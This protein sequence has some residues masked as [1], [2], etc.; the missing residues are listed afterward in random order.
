MLKYFLIPIL[1]VLSFLSG[2]V[3]NPVTGEKELRLVSESAEINLGAEQYGPTRQMQGGDYT[4][5][6]ELTEY[7]AGVGN[8]LASVADRGLPYE[9]NVIN[10]STPN[11]WALPGGKI[12]VNRGLLTEL[13][14]EAE[15]AAVLGHEI[16]HAAARHGAK[17]MERGMLLQ[18]AVM[19]TGLALRENEYAGVVVGGASLGA[20]LV[21]Q[22]YGRDAELESDYYGMSYMRRAGYDPL[23]AVKLQ[24]TFLRLSEGKQNNWLAG[25]FSSHPP[26]RE[27]VEANRRTAAEMPAGGEVG[28]ERYRQKIAALLKAE[29]A[30]VAYEKGRK[31]L[32]EGK[33]EEAAAL[34]EKAI[35]IEPREALFHALLGD[36]RFKKEQYRL[37]IQ[38]YDRALE[39]NN[40]YFAFFLRRGLAQEKLGN[41]RQ[42]Y[43]DLEKSVQLLPTSPALNVLGNL[44]LEQG[45]RQKAKEFFA[46]A[47]GSE[48]EPGKAAARSFVLLDLPDNPGKYLEVRL[49]LDREGY[50]LAEVSNPTMVTVSEIHFTVRFA[51]SRGRERQ[52]LL[53]IPRS[54]ESG[55]A[56]RVETGIGPVENPEALRGIRA[57]VTRARIAR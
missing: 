29:D 18:G 49:G 30:Y 27:R 42:A 53:R 43:V 38:D 39:R 1:L 48:S 5:D 55:Q 32:S 36:A 6:P 37:A 15:L 20:M 47:A 4:A 12:A 19:A 56:A 35:V 16:V 44:A 3:V 17:G 8:R 54:L 33:T 11:A 14:S 25:L 21:N 10:D 51:D 45:D 41:D 28:A 7:V 23:A 34:A 50:L 57:E 13:E 31:A 24:E 26:S 46:A 52:V 2:C 40:S 9:F 22:K